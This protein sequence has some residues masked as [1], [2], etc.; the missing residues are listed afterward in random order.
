LAAELAARINLVIVR[1]RASLAQLEEVLDAS[2]RSRELQM[3]GELIL[4][5]ATS[6]EPGATFL[7]AQN[8][9]GNPITISLHPELTPLENADRL[10]EKAR[11][12]KGSSASVQE[13]AARMRSEIALM[14][15][16]IEK[17]K[18][19]GSEDAVQQVEAEAVEQ[20]VLPRKQV[21]PTKRREAKPHQGF[22]VRE[23][24]APGGETVMWGLN[25]TSNDYVSTRVAK[26]NDLWFH[27]RG[28]A[29]SHVLLR[30]G[31]QPDRVQR[32]SLV[33]AA[34]IAAKNSNQKHAKHV[35]VSYAL[36]KYV[37]KPRKSA[38][39]LVTMTQEKTMFVDP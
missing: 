17:A 14:Q 15:D 5:Y 32:E 26:P 1:R 23:I 35:C 22:R 37:R 8:Y 13:K 25:A 30:T 33:F 18:A 28:G 19:A 20:K 7:E 12:A 6:I 21:P 31:N 11:R 34:K 4:A 38:P 39:G 16:L 24:V 29:G 36:A 3:Q 10:F 9:D 27:V 2:S